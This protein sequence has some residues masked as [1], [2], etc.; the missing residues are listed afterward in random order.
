M[1]VSV[2]NGNYEILRRP[3]NFQLKNRTHVEDHTQFKTRILSMVLLKF[4]VGFCE[5][6]SWLRRVVFII[7]CGENVIE[8][9][10]GPVV[11]CHFSFLEK[12]LKLPRS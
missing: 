5:L 6:I 1:H 10:V 9:D 11:V 2:I 12:L 7:L 3:K 4:N 8:E